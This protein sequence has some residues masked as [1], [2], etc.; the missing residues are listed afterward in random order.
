MLQH[1]PELKRLITRETEELLELSNGISV[2]VA[3]NSFRRVRGYSVIAAICDE[4]AF[5]QSDESANPD[6]EV[7]HA[8]RP[9][10]G[11]KGLLYCLSSPHARSGALYEHDIDNWGRDE[12]VS[13]GVPRPGR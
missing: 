4:I 1:V 10:L 13:F 5:W 2:E 7:L 8:L 12:R 11:A 3:T 6:R 9:A